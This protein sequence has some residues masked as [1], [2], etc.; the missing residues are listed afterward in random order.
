M[1][2]SDFG[3]TKEKKKEYFKDFGWGVGVGPLV[4]SPPFRG[5]EVLSTPMILRAIPAVA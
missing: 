4:G 3:E 1:Y 2:W 5:E